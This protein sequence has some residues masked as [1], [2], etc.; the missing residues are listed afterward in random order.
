M[1]ALDG[2]EVQ[3]R[4]AVGATALADELDL[5][6][7][8]L[9]LADETADGGAEADGDDGAAILRGGEGDVAAFRDRLEE[10][11]IV[12]GAGEGKRL[13]EGLERAEIIGA[14][15]H[16]TDV[17]VLDL[18]KAVVAA[19]PIDAG[20]DEAVDAQMTDVTREERIRAIGVQVNADQASVRPR[21]LQEIPNPFSISHRG[22]LTYRDFVA[23]E[24]ADRAGLTAIFAFRAFRGDRW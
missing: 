18:A 19:V 17:A 22:L 23:R 4:R 15:M 20:E 3:Q 10:I 5:R 16:A 2:G 6:P 9:D 1:D 21:F 8:P 11:G 12:V 24:V 14:V 13:V 7:V